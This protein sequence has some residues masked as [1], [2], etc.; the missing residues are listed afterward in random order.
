MGKNE[1][2]VLITRWPCILKKFSEIDK[3]EFDL[4][5]KKCVI[6]QE[7]MQEMQS[8]R[9]DRMS[10]D[11]FGRDDLRSKE[12]R[13]LAARFVSRSAHLMRSVRRM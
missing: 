4:R 6:D 7:K 10:G 2:T 5:P 9:K 1:A 12:R 13:A 3:A 11:P 8:L